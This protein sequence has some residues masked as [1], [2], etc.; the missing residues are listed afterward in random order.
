MASPVGNLFQR[1]VFATEYGEANFLFSS[2]INANSK[3]LYNRDPLERVQKAAPFL[4][5]D[6][7]AYPAVVDGRIVWIVD[8]YT[9]ATNYPYAQ[10]VTLSDATNNSLA[11]RGAVRVRSTRQVSY[12]R[13]SVKATVDAYDGTVTLY[14]VDETDPVLKAWEGVF[15]GLI[16]S[17]SRRV[18][19][20]CGRTSAT[21]R[22]CS[23]C[24]GRCWFA[25]TSTT[26]S[27]SSRAPVSGRCRTTRR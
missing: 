19:R 20:A 11:A 25:T 16:K 1:A 6:T 14:A 23:R 21:R 15:P 12:I 4:T 13:N 22:T 8:A 17:N 26:R 5:T 24:S 10:A 2:E 7:K 27:T 3:I 18:G 9:T